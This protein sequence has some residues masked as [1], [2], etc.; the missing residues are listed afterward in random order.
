MSMVFIGCMSS[1]HHFR[2]GEMLKSG[3]SE[4]N[5]GYSNTKL[6]FC[7]G[8]TSKEDGISQ[9]EGN[10]YDKEITNVSRS[11]RL[12]VRDDWW[13]FE[14]VEIGYQFE[15]NL[16]LQ[17][18]MRLGLPKHWLGSGW[19]HAVGLGWAVG[20]LPDN[21]YFMDYAI[22]KRWNK[23]V[24]YSS[25]RQSLLTTQL[26]DLSFSDPRFSKPTFNDGDESYTDLYVHARRWLTQMS[27]GAEVDLG[28][29]YIVPDQIN[30]EILLSTPE[31]PYVDNATH[32]DDLKVLPQL[33]LGMGWHY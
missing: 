3:E 32:K 17:F 10:A 24:V 2:K 25:L 14:G 12:G 7:K 6:P 5:W 33:N 28:D 11:F 1:S 18:D 16:V 20:H 30:I 27:L 19:E 26:I 21:T 29:I 31:V 9:C 4:I 23:Y 22:S 13:I 15:T 8:K